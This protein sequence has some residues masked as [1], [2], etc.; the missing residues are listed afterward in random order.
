MNPYHPTLTPLVPDSLHRASCEHDNCGMGAIAHLNGERS[1]RI[2]DHALTSVCCMTHRGAVDADMKTGDGSGV[3][4]QLPLPLFLKE[5]EK[6]GQKI[7]NEK[8]LAVGVFF[9][10]AGDSEARATVTSIATK[11]LN[12]RSIQM[13]GWR[14]VPVDPD[15]LGRVAQASRPDIR[16]L[17]MLAPEGL[18]G[19]E[20][21][22]KLYL[23]R[24]EIELKT[25]EIHGF[26]IPS[27]SSR[28]ISYK[29][30]AM[31]AALRAFYL[32]FAD[33]DYQTA[34]ALYHQRFST[35]TFPAWPLG[36]PFRMMCHNG[37]INTVEGNRNWMTSREEFFASPVWGD[38]IDL[39]KNLIRHGESDS[40]S[41]DHALELLVLS[42]RPLEHAMCMLV[43][44]AYR[45]DQ[46]VSDEVR[47]FYQYIRSFSEPWDGPAGLVFTDG[48]K[49]CASLDRN[50]LRPSR[51]K[52]TKDGELYIG[53]EAGAVIYDDA[54]VVRK[55]RLGPGQMISANTATGEFKYDREIKEELA[56]KK[57]YRRWIDQNQL[58]LRKFVSPAPHAP[59]VDF[60]PL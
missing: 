1:H 39:V 31:P 22:R 43:P 3:L 11:I 7:E 14:D 8:A 60:D 36:Q 49:I 40:A 53:S 42:G 12:N 9:F 59:D 56:R 55:G 32:D 51:Y 47:A 29:A 10:P 20:Y 44:P 2:L 17:L 23:C 18:E 25:V 50:G 21:E 4:T 37:E 34:I 13:I 54:D 16:H 41:L 15:A 58:S 48:T 6:L 52:I 46:D 35:N 24:K 27:F 26:Y 28:L 30:L 57:P 33:P 5:A 45:N 38:E 19:D